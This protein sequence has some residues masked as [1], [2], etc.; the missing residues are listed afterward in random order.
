MTDNISLHEKKIFKQTFDA[1]DAS[2]TG[3]INAEE[4]CKMIRGKK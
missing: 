1:I 3:L 4:I 2:K